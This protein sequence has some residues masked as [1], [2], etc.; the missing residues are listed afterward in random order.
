ML[1]KLRKGEGDCTE[2]K[3]NDLEKYGCLNLYFTAVC[4]KEEMYLVLSFLQVRSY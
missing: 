4:T 1:Q 3:E 2:K